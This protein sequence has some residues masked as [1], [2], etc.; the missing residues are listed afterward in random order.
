MKADSD[1]NFELARVS[2]AR[3]ARV[4]KRIDFYQTLKAVPRG[5]H[6]WNVVGT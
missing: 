1:I 4:H 6:L 2:L 3:A 5:Q